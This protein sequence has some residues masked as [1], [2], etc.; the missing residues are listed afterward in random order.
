MGHFV[1]LYFVTVSWLATLISHF[2]SVCVRVGNCP[3]LWYFCKHFHNRRIH[4]FM[5]FFM[6]TDEVHEC[7]VVCLYYLVESRTKIRLNRSINKVKYHHN[8]LSQCKFLEVN[9]ILS[10]VYFIRLLIASYQPR[11][12]LFQ[13]FYLWLVIMVLITRWGK[14]YH[15]PRHVLIFLACEKHRNCWVRLRR[16]NLEIR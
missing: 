7:I 9:N 5:F 11:I 3:M 16:N 8:T 6:T 13:Y 4:M 14:N 10:Y 2:K 1:S 15:L 12:Y